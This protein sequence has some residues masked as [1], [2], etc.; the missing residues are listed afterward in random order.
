[1]KRPL[2]ISEFYLLDLKQIPYVKGTFKLFGWHPT[3]TLISPVM[4]LILNFKYREWD[5]VIDPAWIQQQRVKDIKL[6][7]SNEFPKDNGVV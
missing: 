6:I 7:V 1:M 5:L 3:L 4:N 2:H